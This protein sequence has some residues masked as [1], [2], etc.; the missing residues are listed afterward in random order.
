M[1]KDD[2]PWLGSFLELGNTKHETRTRGIRRKPRKTQ[3]SEI[4][5]LERIWELLRPGGRAAVIVPD[6]ILTNAQ[7]GYVRKYLLDHFAIWAIVS[8]P[9]EA[10]AHYRASVKASMLFMRKLNDGEA[11]DPSTPVFLAEAASVGYS[12]TGRAAPNELPDIHERWVAFRDAATQ[13][14]VEVPDLGVPEADQ[15][16]PGG[17]E[18]TEAQVVGVAGAA[19]D[20][21]A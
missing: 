8:L 2:Q 7:T 18:G 11:Y 1:K 15:V 10:F 4:V 19:A 14:I 20:D 12:A 13:E 17:D 5:F 16:E 21:G 6:G 9:V 3:K